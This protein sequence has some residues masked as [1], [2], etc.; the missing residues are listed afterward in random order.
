MGNGS[1]SGM[2]YQIKSLK[3]YLSFTFSNNVLQL[4]W[5]AGVLQEAADLSGPWND[6][7]NATSPYQL[8]SELV[9]SNRFYRTKN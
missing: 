7:T 2:I 1:N 6:L 8:S 9:N 3:T 4:T 5:P